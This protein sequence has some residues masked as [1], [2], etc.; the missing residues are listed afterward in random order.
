MAFSPK[1]WID[2]AQIKRTKNALRKAIQEGINVVVAAGNYGP[3]IKTLTPYATV[4]GVISVG[5]AT[6]DGTTIADFSSRGIPG[7][8]L[9][10]PTIVAPG[11]DIVVPSKEPNLI[12]TKR[13]IPF[14]EKQIYLCT[15]RNQKISMDDLS[16]LTLVNGTSFSTSIVAGIVGTIRQMR[17]RLGFDNNPYTIRDIVKTIALKMPSY[18]EFEYGAGFINGAVV[19]EY[20]L[21]ID[22]CILPDFYWGS[23]KNLLN[24]WNECQG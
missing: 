21:K 11:V 2:E 12:L 14:I 23:Y 1:P 3:L 17:S 7:S 10:I 16:S 6:S 4:S 22:Q 9:I 19:K 13:D 5:A 18:K 24:L 20:F 8:K 15:G